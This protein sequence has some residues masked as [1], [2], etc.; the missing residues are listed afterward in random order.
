MIISD[1][2]KFIFIHNPKCAGTSVR[3]K[4][5]KFDD[6]Q[7]WFWMFDEIDKKQVD[8]AHLP[9]NLFRRYSYSDFK[10]LNDYFSFGFVRNPY[11]R[12][13]SAY[14]EVNKGNY[15]ML[16]SDQLSYNEYRKHVNEFILSL[17]S[18][19][20]DGFDMPAR[21]FIPQH[22]MFYMNGKCYVDLILKLEHF[23]KE[24]RKLKF[25]NSKLYESVL[26]AGKQKTNVKS[27]NLKFNDVFNQET[28]QHLNKLYEQ[29]F[30]L[31]GYDKY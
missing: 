31:F 10:L 26:I 4:L 6:R 19:R 22:H 25:F 3:N 24:I 5:L 28:I 15:Q 13:L 16:I 8:K 12:A 29:D 17:S 23:E 11:S 21:H 14:N 18:Q 1:S 27:M 2:Q 20:L 9:L 30:C 7:N